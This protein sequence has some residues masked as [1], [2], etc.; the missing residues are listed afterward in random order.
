MSPDELRTINPQVFGD[1]VDQAFML[2]FSEIVSFSPTTQHELITILV[3]FSVHLAHVY[4]VHAVQRHH[5]W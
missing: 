5:W 4:M 3:E 2:K 1:D